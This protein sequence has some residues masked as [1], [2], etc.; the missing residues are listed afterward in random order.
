MNY[1]IGI[2]K[3]TISLCLL[4]LAFAF[5]FVVADTFMLDYPDYA[6]YITPF[7]T[8]VIINDGIYIMMG[9]IKSFQ[10]KNLKRN[11]YVWTSLWVVYLSLLIVV[12]TSAIVFLIKMDR[13]LEVIAVLAGF[14]LAL[15]FVAIY[16][17][18]NLKKVS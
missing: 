13:H 7:I 15:L 18:I 11:M 12:C 8:L 16:D 14:G 10:K 2:L 9:G 4:F 5:T 6:K 3:L 17:A 1:L